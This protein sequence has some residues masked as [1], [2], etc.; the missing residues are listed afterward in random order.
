M[1]A[2]S[3]HHNTQAAG[4][5]AQFMQLAADLEDDDA[6][7]SDTSSTEDA[8]P[9]QPRTVASASENGDRMLCLSGN[10]H[11][12]L[13]FQCGV[14]VALQELG[15][16]QRVGV[17]SGTGTGCMLVG[18][19]SSLW[20]HT[21]RPVPEEERTRPRHET[22]S[23]SSITTRDVA[24]AATQTYE[25]VDMKANDIL[26]LRGSGLI[27]R[28]QLLV[29]SICEPI[30]HYVGA[31]HEWHMFRKR[32]CNPTHWLRSYNHEMIPA[33]Y[34]Q[35]GLGSIRAGLT[36]SDLC[37]N[38][39]YSNEPIV[40]IFNFTARS[41]HTD[42]VVVISNT[43]LDTVREPPDG[44]IAGRLGI[45]ALGV[46][47]AAPDQDLS[48]ILASIGLPGPGP[49]LRSL[50]WHECEEL[51][52]RLSHR[53]TLANACLADPLGVLASQMW[54]EQMQQ[55]A[56]SA[57]TPAIDNACLFVVDAFTHSPLFD[58]PDETDQTYRR[59]TQNQMHELTTPAT[60]KHYDRAC[61]VK[62]EAI[63][64][65]D[66]RILEFAKN[67]RR[68]VLEMNDLRLSD[69][70][71]GNATKKRETERHRYFDTRL[72][73]IPEWY[74]CMRPFFGLRMT[75]L[76]S[77]AFKALANWGYLLTYFLHA[78]DVQ[79][80]RFQRRNTMLYETL[81]SDSKED[82]QLLNGFGLRPCNILFTPS[83]DATVLHDDIA[84]PRRTR[85]PPAHNPDFD[86]LP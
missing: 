74:E 67:H 86:S 78:T 37:V 21:T 40:P 15:Q 52:P 29:D 26:A 32:I 77:G 42:R 50:E 33:I 39:R 16:L 47:L 75:A 45:D 14:V 19:L 69:D 11:A 2:K 61:C 35:F 66:P 12:G 44:R 71:K 58:N 38:K 46:P 79:F 84:R 25:T 5:F 82:E 56:A 80:D 43:G 8:G 54:F 72:T 7:F 23:W 59:M 70:T 4:S 85:D 27:A 65:F 1:A 73:Q 57:G 17:V 63:Q 10:S 34:H 36:V 3:R 55:D 6:H 68:P 18:A 83:L 13:A 76:P 28:N 64:C 53:L 81:P 62:L 41:S 22:R 51:K 49:L 31:A 9:R 30:R 20:R 60:D 48:R 24:S